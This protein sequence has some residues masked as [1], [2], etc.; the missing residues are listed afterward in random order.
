[1]YDAEPASQFG[2]AAQVMQRVRG[3]ARIGFAS[4]SGQTRLQDLYQSGSAKVR[5]PKVYD[6]PATAVLINTAGGLTGGDCLDYDVS[7]GAGAHAI[8][9]TQ[10]AERAY[11]SLGSCAKVSS[12]LSVGPGGVLEWLPQEAILFNNSSI[13][14]RISADLSG[15]ARLLVLES[16]VLGRTAMGEHLENVFFKDSWRIRRDGKLVFAD[17]VR[18][19]GNPDDFFNGP[20]TGNGFRAMATLLDCSPDAGDRL[21][22]ARA[23]L[24]TLPQ[25]CATAA[26]SAWNGHLITRFL[27]VDGQALRLSLMAF[28]ETYR[29][30]GLPRVWHC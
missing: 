29:S 3:A 12:F 5:L 15:D 27:A 20:A 14:R 22:M 30:A 23:C 19:D 10:T 21:D 18:L 8:V 2:A 17:D 4:G 6:T 16:L 7:I 9:T 11:R 28:L 25:P 1:M 26:A 13:N 24:E